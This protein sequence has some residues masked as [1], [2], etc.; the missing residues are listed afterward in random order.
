MLMQRTELP[1]GELLCRCE[2]I[3]KGHRR[4]SMTHEYVLT[5]ARV[6]KEQTGFPKLVSFISLASVA[7]D[8][9]VF[10]TFKAYST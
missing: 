5:H 1:E 8:K 10:L 3:Y 7:A 9:A 2:P 6:L 4:T